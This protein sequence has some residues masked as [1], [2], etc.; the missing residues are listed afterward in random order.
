MRKVLAVVAALFVMSLAVAVRATETQ[1]VI[2]YYDCALTEVGGYLRT[3]DDE[4]FTWG[5]QSGAIRS[6]TWYAQGGSVLT[7]EWHY[8]NGA[9]WVAFS[10][11]PEPLC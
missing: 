3:Y 11:P 5:Q 2:T 9:V 6:R 8:W 10:G 7:E 4:V 1:L